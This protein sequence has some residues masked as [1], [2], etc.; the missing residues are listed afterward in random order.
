MDTHLRIHISTSS[1]ISKA[2]KQVFG[3]RR[4]SMAELTFCILKV[5]N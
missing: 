1:H 3:T 4:L 2:I 5:K